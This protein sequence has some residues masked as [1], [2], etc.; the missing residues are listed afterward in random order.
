MDDCVIRSS[1]N[2]ET[3]A[4]YGVKLGVVYKAEDGEHVKDGTLFVDLI[5][6]NG[7]KKEIPLS[8]VVFPLYDTIHKY[9]HQTNHY[10]PEAKKNKI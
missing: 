8:M 1:I 10:A 5:A 6:P 3:L 2:A 4:R 9:N 7:N